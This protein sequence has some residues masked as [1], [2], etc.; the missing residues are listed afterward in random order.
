M[1]FARQRCFAGTIDFDYEI[2]SVG[3]PE[4]CDTASVKIIVERNDSDVGCDEVPNGITPNGDGLNDE[5]V[6]DV[7]LNNPPSEFPD[8]E[9]IIFNRWGDIVYQAKPYLND[10]KGTNSSGKDLPQATYYYILWLDISNGDIIKGDV[11]ILK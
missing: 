5:L 2:C 10:W 3:C 11:T 8:N 6:F 4:L 7:L 1:L 9:I